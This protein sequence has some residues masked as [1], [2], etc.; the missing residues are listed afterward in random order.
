M[1]DFVQMGRRPSET[2]PL[3]N[4]EGLA[5]GPQEVQMSEGMEAMKRFL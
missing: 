5:Q 3:A 1:N 4:R 2:S